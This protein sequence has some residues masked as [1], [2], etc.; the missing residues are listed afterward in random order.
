ML[1]VNILKSYFTVYYEEDFF[2]IRRT[3][4]IDFKMNAIKL[5]LHR[6]IENELFGKKLGIY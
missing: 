5:Y 6:G 2:E 1:N 4:L 3:F